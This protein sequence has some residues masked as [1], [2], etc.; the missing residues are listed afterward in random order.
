MWALD[1]RPKHWQLP[2]TSLSIGQPELGIFRPAQGLRPPLRLNLRP[3]DIV[4]T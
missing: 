3:Q 1:D 2:C 4:G